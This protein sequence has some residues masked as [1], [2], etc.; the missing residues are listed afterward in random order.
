MMGFGLREWLFIL[1]PLFIVGILAHGYWRMRSNRHNLKMALD[2]TYV[3]GAG[4]GESGDDDLAFFR[5]ELPNGG[6][7]VRTIPEQTSLDLQT[8]V[9]V[10]MDSIAE[11]IVAQ[12]DETVELDK[13]KSI[14]TRALNEDSLLEEKDS[15]SRSQDQ[16]A[17]QDAFLNRPEKYIVIYVIALNEAFQGQSLLENF[18]ELNL[19]FGEMDIFHRLDVH[20]FSTFSVVNAVEPGTFSINSMAEMSTPGISLFM[21]VHEL[22]DPVAVFNEMV[23]VAHSLAEEL[24]GEVRD[25]SR[26]A[27]T[28]QTVEH[29]RLEIS[30]YQLKNRT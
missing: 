12:R 15:P 16:S 2:K 21:R 9:P 17:S 8:D 14:N 23:D 27:M 19:T 30:E 7:R 26:S 6:A 24:G 5:A 18:V 13:T 20:N 28:H 11:P 1:G 25:E 22:V 29:C 3:S 4:E 10:L